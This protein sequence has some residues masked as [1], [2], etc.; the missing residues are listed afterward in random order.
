MQKKEKQPSMCHRC[1]RCCAYFCLEIDEP[2]SLHEYDDLAWIVAH[3]KTAIH[4][5]GKTWELVVHNPCQH[6]GADGVCRIYDKRPRI[7]RK[8]V[9]GDCEFGQKHLHDYDEVDHIFCN[10]DDLWAYRAER[11]KQRRSKAAK[12]RARKARHARKARNVKKSR[13]QK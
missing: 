9:P 1:S 8:H 13:P 6:L 3:Q 7:C 12:K 10:M 11:I 4:V 5:T 2:E